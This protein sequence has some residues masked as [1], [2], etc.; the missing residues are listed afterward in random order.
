MQRSALGV[1]SQATESLLHVVSI[2][3]EGLHQWCEIFNVVKNERCVLDDP[4][5]AWG[6]VIVECGPSAPSV[7]CVLRRTRFGAMILAINP[8]SIYASQISEGSVL[9]DINGVIVIMESFQSI[10]KMLECVTFPLGLRFVKAGNFYDVVFWDKE[11]GDIVWCGASDLVQVESVSNNSI[12]S[13]NGVHAGDLIIRIDSI[14]LWELSYTFTVEKLRTLSQS[15]IQIEFA[16]LRQSVSHTTTDIPIIIPY[17]YNST[18]EFMLGEHSKRNH[19]LKLQ[20][21]DKKFIYDRWKVVDA[22]MCLIVGIQHKIYKV[23]RNYNICQLEDSNIR[24]IDLLGDASVE[25]C[26]SLLVQLL[27]YEHV[28]T[29]LYSPSSSPLFLV[30]NKLNLQCIE[31]ASTSRAPMTRL[32]EQG[33][34]HKMKYISALF[35][36]SKADFGLMCSL[37]WNIQS[38]CIEAYSRYIAREAV[39]VGDETVTG[40]ISYLLTFTYMLR[41]VSDVEDVAYL[42]RIYGLVSGFCASFADDD[43]ENTILSAIMGLISRDKT[44]PLEVPESDRETAITADE[45]IAPSIQMTWRDVDSDDELDIAVSFPVAMIRQSIR[46]VYCDNQQIQFTIP[47]PSVHNI[48]LGL[49]LARQ[50]VLIRAIKYAVS[51]VHASLHE[52][53]DV[54]DRILRCSLQ[55]KLEN[56]D[57][58]WPIPSPLHPNYLLDGVEY[59]CCKLL[60]SS[61]YPAIIVFRTRLPDSCEHKDTV[62]TYPSNVVSPSKSPMDRTYVEFKELIL[63]KLDIAVPM[64]YCRVSIMGELQENVIHFEPMDDK[65][66]SGYRATDSMKAFYVGTMDSSRPH[67]ALYIAFQF[68]VDEEFTNIIGECWQSLHLLDAVFE[69]DNLASGLT[70]PVDLLLSIPNNQHASGVDTTHDSSIGLV[71]HTSRK[72]FNSLISDSFFDSSIAHNQDNRHKTSMNLTGS[73]QLNRNS[74]DNNQADVWRSSET[75]EYGMY[76]M[77]YKREDDLRQDQCVINIIDVIDKILKSDNLDLSITAYKV[78]TVGNRE[79]IIEWVEGAQPLSSV[80]DEYSQGGE[81]NPIQAYMRRYYYS[82][83]DPYFIME[84]V[85]KRYIHSCAG[86]SVITYILGIGDRHLDNLLMKANG[87][88]LH[89]DFG[90]IFGRDPKPFRPELRFTQ[91]MMFAMGG[92]DSVLYK[93]F[94]SCCSTAYNCIRRSS[95]IVLNLIRLMSELSITDLSMQQLPIDAIMGVKER[96]QLDLDDNKADIHIKTTIIDSVSAVMPSVMESLHRIAVSLR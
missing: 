14:N 90:Y 94:L 6:N 23:N 31:H 83:T 74:N 12:A 29:Q 33:N 68:S 17:I 71:R 11:M 13:K 76:T 45:L 82:P 53:H 40:I 93:E 50:S 65:T 73:L 85:M 62:P 88:F 20:V 3:R 9:F 27:G 81:L 95:Y 49:T 44:S 55:E 30:Q 91:E 19:V 54:R 38:A 67:K 77:L 56:P 69:A 36:A 43:P 79:G 4:N 59:A 41:G 22:L 63:T 8:L 37:F 80:I 89:V 75:P 21:Y 39:V 64:V 57:G 78:L 46:R 70:I 47:S 92:E 51:K 26:L 72:S 24:F 52:S 48:T 86:Y 16:G 10:T 2:Q 84:D 42:E 61:K 58:I 96:L 5:I 66:D 7:G 87:E 1:S 60:K 25:Y 28:I 15:N 18:D 34:E 35:N 32:V